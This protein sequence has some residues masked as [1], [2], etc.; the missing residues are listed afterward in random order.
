MTNPRSWLPETALHMGIGDNPQQATRVIRPVQKAEWES[1][2]TALSASARDWLA[3]Q[4]FDASP[5]TSA[6]VSDDEGRPGD[7]WLGISDASVA[8]DF[9]SLAG[10]ARPRE[11]IESVI[12]R[13]W[14]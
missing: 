3:I 14:I 12:P 5:G 9:A 13:V 1:A 8:A 2:S 7:L 11:R 4:G 10:A 6:Y